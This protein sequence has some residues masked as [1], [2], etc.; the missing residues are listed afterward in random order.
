MRRALLLAF[1][2]LASPV[3]AQEQTS[4]GFFGRLFGTDQAATDEEQG[5]L[6]ERL[7]QDNLSGAGRTV[8]V[9]GF[10]GALSGQATLDR[11]TIADDE[12]IW[13]TL[14][15][16]TLDWNRSALFRGRLEV[17]EISAASI[18]LPRLPAASQT[19]E[20]PAPEASG[21]RLPELPVSV[22][23]GSLRAENVEI[24]APVIG[25]A[26]SVSVDGSLSLANGDGAADLEIARL[27]GQGALS[28][29]AAYANAT[30]QLRIDLSLQEEQGG[31]F[32]TLI[33]LP[34]RPAVAFSVTGDA[35]LSE[36]VADIGLA[37]DG[38]QRLAGQV[39]LGRTDDARTIDAELGGDIAPVFAPEYRDFFGDRIELTAQAL[40]YD[41]GRIGVPDLSLTAREL[42]LDGTVEIGND[43][44]PQLIDL[45]GRIAP[46]TGDD[47]LL[48]LAGD[49]TRIR[50][51]DIS[52]QFDAAQS[53]DWTGRLA[54]E[55][56]ERPDFGAETLT[57][58]GAG[59]I[60]GGLASELT[61]DLDVAARG[62]ESGI[63][64]LAEALGRDIDGRATVTKTGGD[65]VQIEGLRITGAELEIEGDAAIGAELRTEGTLRVT[66]DRV[67]DFSTLAG[68]DLSGT[69]ALNVDFVYAPLG[70][71]FDVS[72]MG[73]TRDLQ[74]SDPYADPLLEGVAQLDL[75]AA[76]DENGFRLDIRQL[77]S[78]AASVTGNFDLRSGGSTATADV[79][80]NDVS[81]LLPE[82]GGPATF[83]F[84]GQEDAERNWRLTADLDA[85]SLTASATGA[86]RDL[87]T[88]N[89]A[90]DGRVTFDAG[91]LAA[92]SEIAGRPLTGQLRV[93]ADGRTD[94][95]L[96]IAELQAEATGAG[97]S[98]GDEN[99]DKLLVGPLAMRVTG[100]KIGQAISVSNLE[101]TNDIVRATGNGQLIRDE[102][103]VTLDATVE[104]ISGFSGL[105]GRSLAGRVSV[106]GEGT[107]VT[108]LT[109]GTVNADVEGS[110]LSIG[111][112]RYDDLLAGPF[113]ATIDASRDGDDIDVTSLE[114]TSEALNATG[115]GRLRGDDGELTVDAR[116]ATLAPLSGLA[117]RPLTGRAALNADATFSRDLQRA[118]VTANVSGSGVS[119]GIAEADRL[120]SG[121]LTATVDATR[122]GDTIQIDTFRFASGLLTASANGRL[123]E[124]GSEVT[125]EARLAD[126]SPFV[127]GF[128]GPLTLDGTVGRQNGRL[129]LDLDAVGPGGARAALDGTVAEDFGTADL[130]ITG[131]APLGLADRFIQP[132]SLSGPVGFDLRLSGPLALQSLSGRATTSGAR[133]AAPTLNTALSDV[134]GNVSLSGGRAQV[135]LAARVEGGGRLSASGPIALSAP[136]AA[137]IETVL[138][139][140]AVS[141]PRFFSTRVSGRIG[142]EGPLTG[143]AR[144]AGRLSLGETNIRIP[145]TGLGG[146]GEIPEIIHINEPPPV[147]G[148]RQRAG[149]LS[150]RSSGGNGG[151]RGGPVYGLD[152][153]IDA[154]NR[155]F[156]RGRGLDSEF[157]GSLRVTG[158][159]ADV[160]PIGA[161]DLIRGRLDIL[162]RRLDLQE[163]RITIQGALIPFLR[164]R[165]ATQAE[166]YNVGVDIVGPADDPEITFSSVPDLPEEEVIS[167]LIFGRGIETLSPLQAARLALAVRTLAGGGSEGI[168]DRI[169]GGTGLDDLDVTTTADGNTAVRAGAYLSENI[170]TD[171]TVDSAG[172]TKLQLNLDV[173]PSLKA[174]GSVS[175]DGES[176]LGLFYERDY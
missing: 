163:A 84:T 12:G 18:Q 32:A 135:D 96:S 168:V 1:L 17:N 164:I 117:G 5:T 34:G 91:N 76:R 72:A 109:R 173:T 102:A 61:A 73:Q 33:G 107:F 71:N 11:L 115:S 10:R 26:A 83:N 142:I 139:N 38:Q 66:A 153:S 155:I 140:V 7:I 25:V 167:R 60:R 80:L 19:M 172:E 40:L 138:N 82:I 154:P 121:N 105:A 48:P 159:T 55:G 157:G 148:T 58:N 22:N 134:T 86:A 100:S 174:R 20:P 127:A 108:D 15:D 110:G 130:S 62:I 129:A 74:V 166:E 95:R 145:D 136:Y 79:A 24:G 50:N 160:V 4:P 147:R 81:L 14:T 123:A 56:L 150:S 93:T 36:F 170:Y 125:V 112:A 119:L 122:D 116:V 151:G 2:L 120:L 75:T 43:G 161:F 158:T 99:L 165:A 133:L 70:G 35:P 111:D 44:I 16:A 46:E 53:E 77:A 104:D 114:I 9:E 90:F 51:A 8:R 68:R 132:M 64:G 89:P 39:R 31:L 3:C 152:I 137:G 13:L 52:V 88:E 23:I 124:A 126:V 141:D 6:L 162:S 171:V 92:F 67:A 118:D 41:D 113:R 85:P 94:A 27:D 176:S 101:I 37:T 149:L 106:N 21:F 143:G 63:A 78:D 42:S 47:V 87:Y 69:A 65:P 156:V 45:T 144:I 97:L 29:D 146:A 175:N 131:N 54:I 57:L 103:Q 128:S 49:E 30:E 28:L 169:R 59:R 98:V